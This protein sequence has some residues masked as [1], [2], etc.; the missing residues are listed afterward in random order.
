MISNLTNLINERFD[1]WMFVGSIVDWYYF[2]NKF[3][4]KDF[5]IVTS[6]HFEP[7]YVGP[8]LGPRYSFTALGRT[9]D[10]FVGEPTGRIE[11]PQQRLEKLKWLCEIF[12]HKIDKYEPRIRMYEELLKNVHTDT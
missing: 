3:M 5:D 9:V 8:K 4:I 11:T 2:P 7:T 6:D 12:P 1:N 10:V